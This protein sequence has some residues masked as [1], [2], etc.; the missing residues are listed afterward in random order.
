MS[1]KIAKA[2]RKNLKVTGFKP[3]AV[4]T[5]EINR[6]VKTFTFPNTDRKVTYETST[7]RHK[8]GTT[9]RTYQDLK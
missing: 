7:V 6:R 8:A 2:I 4:G 5:E 9:R 1:H 3:T